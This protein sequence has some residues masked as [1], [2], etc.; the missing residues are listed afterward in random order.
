MTR[1]L[2]TLTVL[3]TER[4][5]SH[6]V[7]VHLGD[8]GFDDFV[9]NGY[10]D[11]YVKLVFGTD[12]EP[13]LRTY[14]VRR[15]DDE[16]REVA[17]DFV[18]HGDEGVAGPWARAAQPGQSLRLRGPGGAYAPRADADWHL[19]AGDESAIPAIGA[20]LEALPASA[21]A[22]VF[23]EVD[24]PD[25]ELDLPSAA[26]VEVT[27][28]HRGA[29]ADEVGDDR[30]GDNA[31]LVAAVRQAPWL[32]GQPHVFVHGEAN[33]VMHGL[34]GYIRKERGVSAEWASIS[35]YWRRGRTE[36]G[37]R[38]WKSDLAKTEG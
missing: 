29:A 2:V 1:P 12:A 7:R 38:V 37:F 15:V 23:V 9:A 10:T 26:D 35:G 4:L 32:P 36:E 27:W 20:A 19:M 11:A 6:L 13:V 8:P 34:R 22:K 18:V 30:A 21:V 25:G 17:I 28:V 3:R 14:T 33:A 24:G 31:P 5:T 16:K